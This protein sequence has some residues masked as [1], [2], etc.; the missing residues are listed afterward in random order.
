MLVTAKVSAPAKKDP[1][2]ARARCGLQPRAA[3]ADEE[4]AAARAQGQ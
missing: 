2:G 1:R 4:A 3:T